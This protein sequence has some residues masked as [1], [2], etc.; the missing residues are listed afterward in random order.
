MEVTFP[1]GIVNMEDS[2]KKVAPHAEVPEYS[3]GSGYE[4]RA[5]ELD[6]Q[7]LDSNGHLKRNFSGG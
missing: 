6:P 2:E 7:E 5:Y 3:D 1:D 4:G